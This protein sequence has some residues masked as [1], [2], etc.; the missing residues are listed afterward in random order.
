MILYWILFLIPACVALIENK[1]EIHPRS[2]S[3]EISFNLGIFCW[4]LFLTFIIGLRHGVGGDWLNYVIIYYGVIGTDFADLFATARDD[5]FYNII[6]WFAAQNNLGLH[7][8][9]VICAFI[10]A[11]GLTVFC[12]NLPR[13]WLGLT[14]AVPYLVIVVSMGYTRQAM[15]LGLAFFG[16][17]ALA[18]Q[19]VMLFTFFIILAILAHKSAILLLPIAGLAAAKNRLFIIFYFLII[20]LIGYFLFIEASIE[21]YI[22]GYINQDYQSQGALI[23]LTMN[24]I[25]SFL[26]LM[27]YSKFNI[28][29][30]EMRLWYW[31]SL[32]SIF[33]FLVFPVFPSSSALDRIALYLL[34]VQIAVF[35]YF[36]DDFTRNPSMAPLI[37]IL[38]IGYYAAVQFIWLNFASN[39]SSWIPYVN[40]LW[41]ESTAL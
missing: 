30:R 31:I 18:R 17:I 40:L 41:A 29:Q 24:A 23:R 2:G 4:M 19:R 14:V 3:Y 16:L 11:F 25:P 15:A 39:S 22:E 20:A 26:F 38:I 5:P 9:N 12:Q 10:F 33:L 34:P 13:P 32:F 28:P 27:F 37:R 21:Y 6:N 1:R 36:A 35:S 8:V 7:F